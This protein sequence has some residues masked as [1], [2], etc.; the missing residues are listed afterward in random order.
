MAKPRGGRRPSRIDKHGD[1]IMGWVGA[2]P[3]LTLVEISAKL[4]ETVGYRPPPSVVHGFF[5][6]RG[7]TRKKGE[8]RM[9]AI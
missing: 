2:E 8:S 6:R 4:E 7:I 1:L 5:K 9:E 3:D